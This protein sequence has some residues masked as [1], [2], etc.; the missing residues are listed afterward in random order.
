MGVVAGGAAIAVAGAALLGWGLIAE[1]PA[2][3]PK[4]VVETPVTPMDLSARRAVTS[5]GLAMDPTAGDFLVAATRT[6]APGP[7]CQLEVS[8]TGGTSWQTVAPTGN[9]PEG[10][11]A[12]YA[13]E[14]GFDDGGRLYFTFVG[15]AGPPP[16]PTGLWL[17]TSTDR[18]QTFSQPRKLAEPKTAGT[19]LAVSRDTIHVVW[20]EASIEGSEPAEGGWAVGSRLVAAAG[21]ETGLGQHRVIS[22]P[23]GLVAGPTAAVGPAGMV[24]VAYYELPPQAEALG[25]GVDAAATP[26]RLMVTRQEQQAGTFTEPVE[27]AKVR[28]PKPDPQARADHPRLVASQGLA[29]PGLAVGEKAICVSWTSLVEGQLD[30]FLRCRSRADGEWK[31]P[32]QLGAGLASGTDQWLPQVTMTHS[33]RV[34]A[35]F[36]HH[37]RAAANPRAADL[38]YVSGRLTGGFDRPVRISSMSS[39]PQVTP[40]RGWF[41]TRLGLLATKD[42]VVTAWADS[43]NGLSVYPSQTVFA[44]TVDPGSGSMLPPPGLGGGLLLGGVLLLAAGL[45]S[46]SP[47]TSRRRED[48]QRQ[49]LPPAGPEVQR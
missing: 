30:A 22:D 35:V 27:V 1:R 24:S 48:S 5:P 26:W 49:T 19:A 3:S 18:A 43:R 38:Y 42:G 33:G 15:V 28:L 8:G 10:V 47:A 2:Q 7:G 32:V 46:R 13:P 4:V 16:R 41:G 21:D 17:V 44:A 45:W 14:A 39:H 29:E 6:D 34:D 40:G 9:L 23:E 25:G 12:C 31:A 37:R 20:V 36:Y 11:G